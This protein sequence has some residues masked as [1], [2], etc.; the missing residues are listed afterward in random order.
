MPRTEGRVPWFLK[1]RIIHPPSATDP[2][3]RRRSA[4][5]RPRRSIFFLLPWCGLPLLRVDLAF[6]MTL[7]ESLRDSGSTT[8]RSRQFERLAFML[9]ASFVV[10]FSAADSSPVVWSRRTRDSKWTITS[11]QMDL[12]RRRQ[13]VSFSDS[14]TLERPV[15]RHRRYHRHEFLLA[16]NRWHTADVRRRR[17]IAMVPL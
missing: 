13:S 5:D 3:I 6:V 9:F 11:D 10:A 2:V 14:F 8:A 16:S 12:T 7:P 15:A 4:D 17:S 1:S